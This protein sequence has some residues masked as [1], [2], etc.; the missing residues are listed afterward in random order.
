MAARDEES[1]SMTLTRKQVSDSVSMSLLYLCS[2]RRRIAVIER[3]Q[4]L[5]GTPLISDRHD[6]ICF[7]IVYSLTTSWWPRST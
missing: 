7:Y 3:D 6:W 1:V 4:Q 2:A 5:L